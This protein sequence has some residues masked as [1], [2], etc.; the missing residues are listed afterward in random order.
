[1]SNLKSIS[2]KIAAVFVAVTIL[3][4][5][6]VLLN[7]LVSF[8]KT[9]I[10][11]NF[12]TSLNLEKEALNNF[13]LAG[14]LGSAG[15]V[16]SV[17]LADS[18]GMADS[19]E[20]NAKIAIN[21]INPGYTTDAGKNAGEMIEL[22]NLSGST[23]SLDYLAVVY[24]AKPTATNTLGKSTVLYRFPAGS[25]FIG[26]TI[27]LRYSGAPEV[28]NVDS[29]GGAAAG[30]AGS[31]G[32]TAV[33]DLLYDTSLAM[34]GTLSLVQTSADFDVNAVDEGID[35][36]GEVVSSVCWLGG[37]SCL[38]VFSTTV[39]SRSYTTILRNA[40]T[41]E[42]E[43]VAEYTPVYSAENSGL[44]L[45]PVAE[46]E[47]PGSS[48]S[49]S[50]SGSSSTSGLFDA[51]LDAQCQGVIFSEILSYYD[52]D[53]TEQFIE[54][55]NATG[56]EIEL[57]GCQIKY[58]SK[59]YAV[60]GSSTKLGSG[61]YFVIRP[62]FKLTKNPT[63]E[64]TLELYDVNGTV[65]SALAYPHGQKKSASYAL[66]GYNAD[67]TENWQI[68]YAVTP[69]EANVYQEYKTCPAGKVINEA[70]GNCVKAATVS[71]ALAECPEGKYRNPATGR[72]KNISS[73]SGST[74]CKEG[75]ERNPETGRCRKIKSNDG[76]EYPVVPVTGIVEQSTFIALWAIG[77]VALLGAGYVVFQFR[78]EIKY[79]FRKTFTKIFRR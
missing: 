60:A 78:R 29:S 76:A 74:E 42:Y 39:K 15:L 49:A 53:A 41:G 11:S 24:T 40:E 37:E 34:A 18:V 55:Y 27:L 3:V 9:S 22:V 1:M 10:K 48:G 77:V 21:A 38:P 12:G 47:D 56:S 43:H 69:G 44:Y 46:E 71:S 33:A 14:S 64:N 16:S 25:K 17:D 28:T 59:Y 70:T 45:P 58:K 63:T 67:G 6:L 35:A 36:Y 51:T 30:S 31:S 68:T 61:E 13:S 8:R 72:C 5:P 32:A 75:Y 26:K 65:V 20:L 50:S 73:D 52:A 62:E 23:L 66:V 7:F 2:V 19:A 54:L 79:F 4:Q 57:S